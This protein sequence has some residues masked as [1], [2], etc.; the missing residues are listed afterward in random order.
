[1]TEVPLLLQEEA[2]AAVGKLMPAL[3]VL[4]VRTHLDITILLRK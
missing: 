1:M 4:R 2:A 3:S